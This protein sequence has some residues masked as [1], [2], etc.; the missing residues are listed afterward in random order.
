VPSIHTSR[1]FEAELRELRGQILLMGSRCERAVERA[2]AAFWQGDN[3]LADDVCEI[4]RAIDKDEITIDALILHI[5]ALRQPVATDL[6]GVMAALKLVTDLERIGDEAVNIAERVG[7]GSYAHR[8]G[9]QEALVQMGSLAQHMLRSAL[10]AFVHGDIDRAKSIITEDD[11]VDTLYG[12]SLDAVTAFMA[13][14]PD[15]VTGAIAVMKVAKF[16]ERIA[17]HATNI[18]EEVI[19]AVAGQDVRHVKPQAPPSARNLRTV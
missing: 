18:A 8:A 6:R 11:A 3:A 5:L 10:D 9:V 19:F 15:E 7:Q 13:Q 1:E 14:H 4:D 12:Q 17:D 16:L 2:L